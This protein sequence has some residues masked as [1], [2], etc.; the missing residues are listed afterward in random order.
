MA[1]AAVRVFGNPIN[2]GTRAQRALAAKNNQNADGKL[3]QALQVLN[4]Q[5]KAA[6]GGPNVATVSTTFGRVYNATGGDITYVT[7]HD[8]SGNVSGQ[9]TIQN[10]QWAVFQHVG[11]RG[12][13]RQGSVAALVYNIEDF[14]DSMIAWNNPWKK[15]RGGNNTD[16]KEIPYEHLAMEESISD[17]MSAP[18][19]RICNQIKFVFTKSTTTQ[20][21]LEITVDEIAP[22]SP[23]PPPLLFAHTSVT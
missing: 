9:V 20:S 17:L 13:N 15:A 8:G 23:N 6:A 7:A 4:L 22:S 19:T 10:G 16:N 11:T 2:H 18:A 3:D 12:A 1:A 14:G 5:Q 21:P